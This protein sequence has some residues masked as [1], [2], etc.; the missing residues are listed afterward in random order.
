[1]S[2]GLNSVY[3]ISVAILGLVACAEKEVDFNADIRPILN[4]RC[5]SCHGGVK[6]S[7]GFGLVFREN[8][9]K[10]TENGKIG[11]VPGKPTQSEMY[12]RIIHA[13]PEMRMPLDEAPLKKEEIALIKKWIAQGAK[14]EEHW[15]YLPPKTQTPPQVASAW[16]RNDIDRFVLEKILAH[17]LTPSSEADR[18]TLVR[19]LF[20]DLIGL[21]PTPEELQ[22]FLQDQ[23]EGAYE[24]LVDYLL[25]S[26][27]YGEHWASMWLDLA[28]YADSF[29]YS[30][31]LNREIW[32]Y[33]DWVI[34]ALNADM[35]FD[36]FTIDQLAGDLLPEA[37]IDQLVA[38]AFH[39]NSMTNGEGGAYHEEFRN[40]AVID[41]VNTTWETW[42]ATTMGCVQC[43]NHPYDPI[44]QTDFYASFALFNNTNDRN[45]IAEFP[46]LK[47]LEPVAEAQL[48]DIKKWIIAH[49]TAQEAS[50]VE[51]MILA[52]EPK[53]VPTD[54]SETDKVK[55]LNRIGD[56]YMSVY[57]SA[58][59][60]I[61]AVDLG[62]ID[63]IYLHYL[64]YTPKEGLVQLRLDS[65]DGQLIGQATLRKT[66]G[67]AILPIALTT[68]AKQ[69]DV[70][71][72]ISSEAEGFESRIDG[73]V[74]S[75]RLSGS[76]QP[77]YAEIRARIDSLMNAK[78]KYTTPIMVER[79]SAYRR[80]TQLFERGNWL[81]KGQEVNPDIPELFNEKKVPYEDRLALAKWLVSEENPLTGRVAVNRIWGR[82]F[83]KGIVQSMEDFGTMGDLPSHPALLDWLALQFSHEQGWQFKNLI[84]AIV[85]SA[86]YRQSSK[87]DAIALE[88]DPNNVW[89]ARSPRKRLTAEQVR[90]Q[91]LAVSG[92]LSRKMYGPSVMPS[93]PDGI[94]K[95]SF[96]NAKWETSEGEDRYRRAIYTF[97]KRSAPYP[98]FIT[99]DAAGREVCLSRRITTNTPLQALVTLNDPVFFDA[100]RALA[101]KIMKKSAPSSSL[102]SDAY[103]L[104]MGKAPSAKQ[105]EVLERLYQETKQYYT[106]N[107]AEAFEIALSENIELA[108]YTIVAN[109]L[110]NMDE[111]IVKS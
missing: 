103:N 24:N 27:H 49:G 13:D 83:G 9:L 92:L 85:M 2:F 105:M 104:M 101:Q 41:R 100:A 58:F 78:P 17:G 38:T 57:D 11:I 97:I 43:H 93:Q 102:L 46:V 71:V 53:I 111:F 66:K 108:V 40:A 47:T 22:T 81:V 64:Q 96:S 30:S 55:F 23:S 62:Q 80:K 15:A 29:G 1:M 65:P 107:Q 110:M 89:L 106:E 26:P 109:S 75:P 48:E 94:W 99:F 63:K 60:K 12:R 91:A 74:L 87:I 42:Q 44:K 3:I 56:D 28:R 37:S 73:I 69:G 35:P 34:N 70:Y 86:T 20:L 95:V 77:D 25:V 19:R 21:P 14:W 59:I 76:T 4:E 18:T 51:K 54:F 52:H 84:K 36:Q 6:R 8:A 98:S 88:K 5:V 67:L 68:T 10:E 45:L 72:T 39:R 79:P 16:I 61:P 90:D 82:L 31:D 50:Q 33:R 32:K 7:G